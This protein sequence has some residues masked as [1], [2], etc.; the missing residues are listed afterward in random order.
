V[1]GN[2]SGPRQGALNG[3][4]QSSESRQ[5]GGGV[6]PPQAPVF[7]AQLQTGDTD[8]GRFL[9]VLVAGVRELTA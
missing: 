3:Y 2:R 1:I 7:F 8:G 5:R 9:R 6:E 4:D